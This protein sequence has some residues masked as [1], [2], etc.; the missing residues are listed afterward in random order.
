QVDPA[1]ELLQLLD[2]YELGKSLH[3][4]SAGVTVLGVRASGIDRTY[5]V[6]ESFEDAVHMLPFTEIGFGHITE[7]NPH[8]RA[9]P[10]CHDDRDGATKDGRRNRRV[11]IMGAT[12]NV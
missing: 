3:G 1:I 5:L 7:E 2:G 12:S 10:L 4:L 9:L 8:P 6:T 11:P